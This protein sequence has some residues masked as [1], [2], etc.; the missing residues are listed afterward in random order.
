VTYKTAETDDE[1]TFN[2]SCTT[3]SATCDGD[4]EYTDYRTA[5]LS[6]MKATRMQAVVD[7][8]CTDWD[9]VSQT[10]DCSNGLLT[11]S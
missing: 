7:E 2:S 11:Y 3:S 4:T 6:A 5:Y 10:R 1:A 8:A 9:G